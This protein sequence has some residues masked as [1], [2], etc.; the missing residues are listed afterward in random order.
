MTPSAP[1]PTAPMPP[2][3]RPPGG[4][5]AFTAGALALFHN[6]ANW[7]VSISWKRFFLLS[8]LLLIASAIL[9]QLPPFSYTMGSADDRSRSV[10]ITPPVPPVP[11]VPRPPSGH[12][13]AIKIEKKDSK[14][15]D[16][17]ISIDRDG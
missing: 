6:Y 1:G 4:W 13:P 14:G 2:P 17:V 8:I 5:H 16:V 7:L 15:R 11:A 3:A 9:Q 10:V 12:D